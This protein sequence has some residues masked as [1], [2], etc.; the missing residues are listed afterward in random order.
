PSAQ[1]IV[2]DDEVTHLLKRVRHGFVVSA[3][4]RRV[5]TTVREEVDE[6]LDAA[7]EQVDVRRFKRLD[8]SSRE[9]EGNAVSR[10]EFGAP[11]DPH[12]EV[13]GIGGT[14]AAET[15]ALDQLRL[16]LV[17]ADMRAR[18]DVAGAGPAEE[19]DLPQPAGLEGG[20]SRVGRKAAVARHRHGN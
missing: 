12:L 5:E 20:R 14:R 9:A 10:P 1:P 11:P 18:I 13:T 3:P 17:A 6:E 15:G 19:A 16:G 7:L 8:E 2:Q 4:R